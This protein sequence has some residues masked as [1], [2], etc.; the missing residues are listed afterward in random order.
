M[1]VT[2]GAGYSQAQKRLCR[3]VDLLVDDVVLLLNRVTLCESHWSEREETSRDNAALVDGPCLRR[4][5]QVSRDLLPHELIERE[6]VVE[7]ID[8][9]VAI[10]PRIAER[11][12]LV[13]ASGI[14]I[15]SH[16]Q[17]VAPP[18]LAVMGRAQQ[19]LDK[20]TERLIVA[21]R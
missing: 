17:P 3:R 12:I 8:N 14:G 2:A 1:V 4:W 21:I 13:D 19:A 5:K 16:I 15:P 20:S 7:R 11:V 9:V 10:A 18:A 6:I